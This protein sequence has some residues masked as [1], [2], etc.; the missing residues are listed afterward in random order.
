M[1]LTE[2]NSN[3]I[4][5]KVIIAAANWTQGKKS[6]SRAKYGTPKNRGFAEDKMQLE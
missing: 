1:H 6:K 5:R 3:Q 2:R 4:K